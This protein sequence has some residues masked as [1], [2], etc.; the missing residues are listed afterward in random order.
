MR[1]FVAAVDADLYPDVVISCSPADTQ[2]PKLSVLTEAQLVV[3]VLSES[4]AGF[5]RGKKFAAYRQLPKLQ[6]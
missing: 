5:D 4:T 3:E 1:L 6:E 2:D